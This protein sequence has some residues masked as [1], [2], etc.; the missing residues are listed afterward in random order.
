MDPAP[1]NHRTA[2]HLL[3]P[4]R[5]SRSPGQPR[6]VTRRDLTSGLF[7]AAC[8]RSYDVLHVRFEGKQPIRTTAPVIRERVAGAL[9]H[10]AAISESSRI[11]IAHAVQVDK[12]GNNQQRRG[13]AVTH[14]GDRE[15]RTSSAPVVRYSRTRIPARFS[16]VKL[17]SCR[18]GCLTM[19]SHEIAPHRPTLPMSVHRPV[20]DGCL[21]YD[22]RNDH[23]IIDSVSMNQTATQ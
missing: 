13:I 9:R 20:N 1:P 6:K 8:S 4:F 14:T 5:R 22:M 10:A 19:I 21:C 17:S 2:S 16:D 7:R 18:C 3:S 12:N 11:D 23:T 15:D